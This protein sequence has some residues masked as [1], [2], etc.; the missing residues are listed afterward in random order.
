MINR[1]NSEY[2]RELA[3]AAGGC[4]LFAFPLQMTM[5]MW[6]LGFFMERE[7][8]LIFMIVGFALLLGLSYYSGFARDQPLKDDIL[9]AFSAFGLGV[10]ISAIMLLIFNVLATEHSLRE[11]IGKVALQSI[12]AGM[13]AILARKQLGVADEGEERQ[14]RIDSYA[15]EL[16]AMTGGAIFIAFNVA[17]TDEIS[18]ISHLMTPWHS[19]ILCLISLLLL[20]ALVYG[21]ELAGQAQ[22]PEGHGFLSVFFRFSLAG[23]GVAVAVSLYILWSFGRLDGTGWNEIAAMLAVLAF[24]ASIGAATARLV[25]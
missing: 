10:I 3:R 24:P 8:L 16:F 22:W 1:H 6:W 5:E 4:I 11:I 9:D 18:L 13:G 23:Y 2:A 12:P 19:V 20:H 17:P 7:R 15:G 25:I 14:R 21:V